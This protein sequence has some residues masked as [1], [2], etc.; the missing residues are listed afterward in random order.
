M[1]ISPLNATVATMQPIPQCLYITDLKRTGEAHLRRVVDEGCAAGVDGVL[2]R[3]PDMPSGKLLALASALRMITRQHN[4]QLIIHSQAD[5]ARAIEAD[6]VHLSA[7]NIGEA[8]AMRRWL[9]NMPITL[10]TACHNADELQHSV[11]LG[12]DF[13]L[14][15]PVFPTASHPGC[16]AL[17]IKKFQQLAALY[18]IKVIAL[19]G[20]TTHNRTQLANYPI[21]AMRAIDE[22]DDITRALASLVDQ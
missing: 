3:E 21:A 16:T 19:G 5:I 8:G 14:L 17:G 7:S 13:A 11:D 15:S 6:G 4:A 1:Q 2:L 18:P 10:S 12:I 20:I 9:G 22:A